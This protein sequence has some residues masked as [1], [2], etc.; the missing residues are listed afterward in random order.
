MFSPNTSTFFSPAQWTC[1]SHSMCMSRLEVLTTWKDLADMT[2]E[3]TSPK[4]SLSS[5]CRSSV[6]P[7][8]SRRSQC[9]CSG[10][11]T[12]PIR[13]GMSQR[14]RV[15]T[16]TC[17][18]SWYTPSMSV[19]AAMVQRISEKGCSSPVLGT[20]LIASPFSLRTFLAASMFRRV[21]IMDW[22]DVLAN[23]L[24]RS[25]SALSFTRLVAR[26]ATLRGLRDCGRDTVLRVEPLALGRSS[27]SMGGAS[28]LSTHTDT[29]AGISVL[30]LRMRV[31]ICVLPMGH[32]RPKSSFSSRRGISGTLSPFLGRPDFSPGPTMAMPM[33]SP[34]TSA[35]VR[36]PTGVLLPCTVTP[37]MI[38]TSG[39]GVAGM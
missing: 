13:K 28:N 2:P 25:C 11:P 39:L 23:G 34:H 29:G 1:T 18:M 38:S 22:P 10:V 32:C 9:S 16:R 37:E 36:S 24:R 27:S 14:G 33:L 6:S 3:G 31:R 17:I 21:A 7:S 15:P 30:F 20:L 19:A 12:T 8:G 35:V 4:S 26:L 5:C